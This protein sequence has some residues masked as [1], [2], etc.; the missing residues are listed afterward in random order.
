M[1]KLRLNLDQIRVTSFE[2][3]Q[4]GDVPLG[5]V[6]G[7]SDPAGAYTGCDYGKCIADNSIGPD[8]TQYTNTQPPR[9]TC[10]ET[11]YWHYCEFPTE[12]YTQCNDFT[13]YG[14]R[15]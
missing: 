5:T 12:A 11:C 14:S 9:E 7:H 1:E 15:C 10:Q 8:C 13:C 4:S 6:R 2:P 3:G